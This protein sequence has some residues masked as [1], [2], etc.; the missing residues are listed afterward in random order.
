MLTN[1]LTISITKIKLETIGDVHQGQ[2]STNTTGQGAT[3]EG[4]GNYIV[5]DAETDTIQSQE[6][7]LGAYQS[8]E[9]EMLQ[10]KVE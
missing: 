8:Q 3:V 5:E 7:L 9:S 1:I 10:S 2:T 4:N 6:G